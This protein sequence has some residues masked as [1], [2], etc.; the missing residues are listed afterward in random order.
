MHY[1]FINNIFSFYEIKIF[2]NGINLSNKMFDFNFGL[3]SLNVYFKVIKLKRFL[4]W[5]KFKKSK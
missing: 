3:N 5:K 4:T 2:S 1:N